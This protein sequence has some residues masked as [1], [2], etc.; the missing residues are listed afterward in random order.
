MRA[1]VVVAVVALG[2]GMVALLA[3]CGSDRAAG[4]GQ[5]QVDD[6]PDPSCLQ[7]LVEQRIPFVTK[8]Q[9]HGVRTPVEVTGPIAGVRLSP[10]AGYPPV[11]DCELARALFEAAP[12]IERAGI[13]ELSFSGAYNYR[14]RHNSSQLSAHSFGLAIDVHVLRGQG[15]E[16]DIKRDFERGAGA[17]RSLVTK[18]GDLSGCVGAPR[19]TK[20]RRL[21]RLACELKHHSAFRVIIT[22]DD[23]RD[24]RDHLH[25]EAFPNTDARI[26]RVMGAF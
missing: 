4:P 2:T 8:D 26:A 5:S 9:V 6:Q 22:P 19:T 1:S 23:D 12:I 25:L 15:G 13:T 11:M 14:T 17:W 18:Q 10:R 3:G 16:L 21:R 7:Y 24:H 20:G